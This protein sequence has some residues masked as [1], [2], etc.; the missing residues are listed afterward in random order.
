[1]LALLPKFELSPEAEPKA[2]ALVR[3][4][5][6]ILQKAEGNLDVIRVAYGIEKVAQDTDLIGRAA[7]VDIEHVEPAPVQNFTVEPTIETASFGGLRDTD[8]ERILD[9]NDDMHN[10]LTS[11]R[12][13]VSADEARAKIAA[14]ETTVFDPESHFGLAA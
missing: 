2:S 9:L 3:E 4:R 10:K 1:M 11:T 8:P 6:N 13:A 5:L 12:N 14:I 7:R